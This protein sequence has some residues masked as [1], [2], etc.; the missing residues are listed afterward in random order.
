VVGKEEKRGKT[1]NITTE[2][3]WQYFGGGDEILRLDNDNGYVNIYELTSI[4]KKIKHTA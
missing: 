3:I 1:K 2:C 4:G